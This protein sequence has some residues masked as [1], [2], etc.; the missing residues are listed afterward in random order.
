MENP[1]WK[2]GNRRHGYCGDTFGGIDL[3]GGSCPL[4]PA[5]GFNG[6]QPWKTPGGNRGIKNHESRSYARLDS[7]AEKEV[8][9]GLL[10]GNHS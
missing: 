3:S 4:A 10:D 6:T 8:T 5:R 9:A 2:P 1:R 7:P